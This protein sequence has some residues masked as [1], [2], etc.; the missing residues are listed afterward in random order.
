MGEATMAKITEKNREE[1][2]QRVEV[3]K[4]LIDKTLQREKAILALLE[5]DSAGIAYKKLL[6]C[7]FMIY[8]ATLYIAVNAFSVELFGMNN[9]DALNEGRKSLYRAIIYLEEIVTNIIDAPYSEY[10]KHVAEISNTP[11][12]RRFLLVKKLG[13]AIRMLIDAYGDNTK[14][15]WAFVELT[16]RF[17]TVA[18]NII[19]LRAAAKACFDP[20]EPDYET[21]VT[22]LRLIKTL[23]GQ[24]ADKYRDRYEL[25]T[26]RVDDIRLGI[27]Y[28]LALRRL[29]IITGE[30]EEA[31][32]AKKKAIVWNNKMEADK[33]KGES[34]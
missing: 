19:D 7:E 2:S 3:Y 24:S 23:I 20:N 25:S 5:R 11:V 15:K 12:A 31:E 32:E 27:S 34:R 4:T 14:W 33:K 1:F 9:V 21:T 22:F 10:E 8:L 29:H 16:G 17:A 18:K 13:L 28:L 6:L 26:R 30:E